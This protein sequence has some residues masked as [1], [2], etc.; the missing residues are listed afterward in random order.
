MAFARNWTRRIAVAALVIAGVLG[1]LVAAGVIFREDVLHA[2]LK[3]RLAAMG[4]GEARFRV[5]RVSGDKIVI[6]DARIGESLSIARLTARYAPRELLEGRLGGVEIEGLRADLTR[7]GGAAGFVRNGLGPTGDAEAV[8]FPPIP[9]VTILDARVRAHI[10]GEPVT[11]TIDGSAGPADGSIPLTLEI[12]LAAGHGKA[13][14]ALT[15]TIHPGVRTYEPLTASGELRLFSES[16]VLGATGLEAAEIRIPISLSVAGGIVAGRIQDPATATAKQITRPGGLRLSD[17]TASATGGFRFSPTGP[18]STN[19]DGTVF[20]GSVRLRTGIDSA[21]VGG[22]TVGAT[23]VEAPLRI[24]SAA[25]ETV[26]ELA[27]PAEIEVASLETRDGRLR[28][29]PFTLGVSAASDPLLRLAPDGGEIVLTHA[30]RLDP[31][32]I[33][34]ESPGEG[35]DYLPLSIESEHVAVAGALGADGTYHAELGM[36]ALSVLPP[37]RRIAATRLEA[38]LDMAPAQPVP[39]VRIRMASVRQIS[40]DPPVVPVSVIATLIPRGNR[41]DLSA[42]ISPTGTEV[43]LGVTGMHDIRRGIGQ[44]RLTLR[45]ADFRPGGLQ[46]GGIVPALGRMKDAGGTL[47]ASAT[48]H[49]SDGIDG[50]AVIGLENLSATLPAGRIEGISG[51]VT[52]NGLDPPSTPPRQRVTIRRFDAGPVLSD[53]VLRFELLEEGALM[54]EHA[55]AGIAGGRIGMSDQKIDPFS[56]GVAATIDVTGLDLAKLVDMTKLGDV[57]ATGQ[58]SGTVPIRVS[59][60]AVSVDRASLA[61]EGGGMLR[62]RSE[63]AARVLAK[64]G[65]EVQLMLRALEDFRYETLTLEVQKAPDGNTVVTL[66]T[67]GHNPAVLDGRP[68]QINVNLE[69]N[70]DR[71][72]SAVAEWYRLS[73]RALRDIVGGQPRKGSR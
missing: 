31:S 53:A 11:A 24:E 5:V 64:G 66:R 12:G 57:G 35:P 21:A 60:G 62:I 22:A 33:V 52:F 1:V 41:A 65:R 25:S 50:T 23:T 51:S 7:T 46:P 68:F 3:N 16:I 18:P 37:G 29:P 63:Q 27:E 58:L 73:G 43:T 71:V 20:S 10:A 59:D 15:A 19:G 14:G 2:V 47:T 36:A 39:A 4:L 56:G 28:T 32:R 9:R 30:L 70:L 54:I 49:W 67:L 26:V 45:G 42:A 17:A 61:T 55:E 34:V 6:A 13:D 72:L 8:A 69:T 38:T 44:A 48:L 40:P